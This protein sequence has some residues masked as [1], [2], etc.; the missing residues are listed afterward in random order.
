MVTALAPRPAWTVGVAMG[1][2]LPLAPMVNCDTS[3]E[4]MF[5]TYRW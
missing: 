1:A 4:T 5:A 3:W 2:R